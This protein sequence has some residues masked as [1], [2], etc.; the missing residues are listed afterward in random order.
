MLQNNKRANI[1]KEYTNLYKNSADA[2]QF[3]I[4]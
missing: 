4:L 3:S 1:I 2:T